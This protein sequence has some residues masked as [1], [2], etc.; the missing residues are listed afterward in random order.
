M[1]PI[2]TF[3]KQGCRCVSQA[4][5]RNIQISLSQ[6]DKINPFSNTLHMSYISSY[7]QAAKNV[8][9]KR[10]SC[11]HLMWRKRSDQISRYSITM[12]YST[13]VNESTLNARSSSNEPDLQH[14]PLHFDIDIDSLL[15][16]NCLE[17][18]R[19]NLANRKMDFDLDTLVRFSNYF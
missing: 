6:N 8:I 1:L 19:A 12:T 14:A 2:N 4:V 11:R 5:I 10:N 9:I 17:K 7:A 15:H 18:L 16:V 13:T 3:V